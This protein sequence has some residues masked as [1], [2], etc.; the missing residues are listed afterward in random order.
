MIAVRAEGNFDK[1]VDGLKN[2]ADNL[3]KEIGVVAWNTA[4]AGKRFVADVVT[5]EIR[6]KKSDVK[7]LVKQKRGETESFVAVKKSSRMPLKRFSPRQTQKGV[8]YRIEKQGKRQLLRGGFM[9][10]RPGVIAAKLH[11]HVWI[12]KG[13]ME[14]GTSGPRIRGRRQREPI[15][16]PRGPSPWGVLVVGDNQEKVSK[17]LKDELSKQLGRRIKYLRLKQSGVI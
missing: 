7:D 11:G 17:L 9:G 16:I 10:P 3:S 6:A 4:K 1:L 8:T 14:P 15:Y 12:R 13:Y 2:V 5:S